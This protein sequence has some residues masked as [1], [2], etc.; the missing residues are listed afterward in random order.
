M[1]KQ[2]RLPTVRK[3][4]NV[5]IKKGICFN[6]YPGKTEVVDR[7][8]YYCGDMEDLEDTSILWSNSIVCVHFAVAA[9]VKGASHTQDVRR[10]L[11]S[12]K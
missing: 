3:M 12:E 6:C 8:C 10:N 11:K 2:V 9:R 5:V 1:C 7:V 4:I